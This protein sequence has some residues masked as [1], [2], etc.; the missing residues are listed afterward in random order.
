MAFGEYAVMSGL[1]LNMAKA[2]LVPLFPCR[3]DVFRRKSIH[4][5]HPNWSNVSIAHEGTY[6]GF[7]IGPSGHVRQWKKAID[8]Y[9]ERATHW[10]SLNLG[11]HLTIFAYN[12]FAISVLSYLWQLCTPPPE[13]FKAQSA[14]LRKLVPGP[15]DWTHQED[16]FVLH[17]EL[18]F[19]SQFKSIKDKAL[20]AKLRLI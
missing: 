13:F 12:I 1:K 16:L 19:P 7:I 15:G 5:A 8:K 3:L 4:E 9:V 10:A 18:G 2:V 20:A 14:L 11:L 17:T 6:L